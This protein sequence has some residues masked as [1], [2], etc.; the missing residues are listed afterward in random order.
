MR[1]PAGRWWF[2]SSPCFCSLPGYGVG[3]QTGSKPIP[4]PRVRVAS[5]G[6][7]TQVSNG[8]LI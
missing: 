8:A 6:L 7:G 1:I 4:A 5:A 2:G 3:G